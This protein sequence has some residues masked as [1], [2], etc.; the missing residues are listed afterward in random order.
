MA[1]ADMK[2]ACQIKKQANPML[3]LPK[4]YKQ[5]LRE[6]KQKETAKRLKNILNFI[7]EVILLY[8]VFVAGYILA[9]LLLLSLPV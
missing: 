2:K 3:I 8:V 4:N 5:L 1:N 9:K 7:L 6:R